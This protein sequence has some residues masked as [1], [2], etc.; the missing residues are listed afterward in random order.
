MGEHPFERPAHLQILAVSWNLGWPIAGGVI[1]GYWIDG[2]LG[3]SPAATLLLG[4]GAL[5]VSVWRLIE[6][7]RQE[8]DARLEQGP[9]DPP[10]RE[11]AARV[12]EDPEPDGRDRGDPQ[13][14]R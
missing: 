13:D 3:S 7:G 10:E 2:K 6:L 1:F 11:P 8:Q 9:G 12:E 14:R 4:I 5:T